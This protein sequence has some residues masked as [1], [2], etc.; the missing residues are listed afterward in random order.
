MV[1]RRAARFEVS[2]GAIGV[3]VHGAL[4][5]ASD[6]GRI[7]VMVAIEG[8]GD[9]STLRELG[10][11]L[12][13]HVAAAAPLSLSVDDLDPA[14]VERERAIFTEQA[15]ASGK[16]P[17]VIEK[18]VEG[19]VR[20]FHEE[21]VL[22][23]QAYVREPDVT[24]EQLVARTAKEI[25]APVKVARFVRFALGEGLDRGGGGDFAAEVAAMTGQKSS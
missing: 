4:A 20:K 9:R 7:G 1:L 16:P 14:H 10:R 24:I 18:M 21:S 2:P 13:L 5:G 6:L 12:A 3:Y 22:L 8:E 19:R 15:M 11:N 17:A 23:K 25:G